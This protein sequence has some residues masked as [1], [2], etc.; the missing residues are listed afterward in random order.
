MSTGAAEPFDEFLWLGNHPATDL[1]NTVPVIDG[2]VVELLP[3]HGAVLRWA[4][5]IGI[6]TDSVSGSE[7]EQRRTVQF[8]HRLRAA[9]RRALV[10][11][12]PAP[13]AISSI[14]AVLVDER[15]SL[16]VRSFGSI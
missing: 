8:V 6:E 12:I 1:C 15:G 16:M 11:D 3:D 13:S 4:A 7:R 9:T 2:Q 5:A 10:G 14:N